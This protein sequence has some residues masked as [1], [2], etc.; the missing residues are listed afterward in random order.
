M[1]NIR[2]ITNNTVE[3]YLVRYDTDN[4]GVVFNDLEDS[5][6]ASV[7]Y[8]PSAYSIALLWIRSSLDKDE[9][10]EARTL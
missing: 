1:A 6:F 4:Y 3:D 7:I 8:L 10:N 9:L 5:D 2:S